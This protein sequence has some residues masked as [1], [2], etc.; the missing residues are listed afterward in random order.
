MRLKKNPIDGQCRIAGCKDSARLRG[1]CKP[2]YQEAYRRR[3]L[4]SLGLP[5]ARRGRKPA[6]VP[7][8]VVPPVVVPAVAPSIGTVALDQHPSASTYLDPRDVTLVW[9]G[10]P[11]PQHEAKP[12]RV[13]QAGGRDLGVLVGYLDQT[14]LFRV[15]DGP[16]KGAA[17]GCLYSVE[18]VDQPTQRALGEPREG[19]E[20]WVRTRIDIVTGSRIYLDCGGNLHR[21]RWTPE[22]FACVTDTTTDTDDIPF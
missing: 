8:E 22:N 2:H 9:R 4:D 16:Q 17:Y 13:K 19:A 11:S 6:V 21:S 18:P 10:E 12:H 20:V 5:S 14:G 3:L 1:F 15:T 7:E